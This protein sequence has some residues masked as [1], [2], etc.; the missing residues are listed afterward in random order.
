M[1]YKDYKAG[2]SEDSFWYRARRKLIQNLLRK[3]LSFP[4][5]KKL[6]ILS[7]GVGTGDELKILNKF[8][9]IYVLDIN[10]KAL[11]LVPNEFCYKKK[12]GDACE[13]PFKKDFFDV[14]VAFDVL[15]H[16]S[17]HKSAIKE[18]YRVLKKNGFFVFSVPAFQFLFSSHDKALDH[19]R[20]YS[21]KRL[22]LLL[23]SFKERRLFYWNFFMFPYSMLRLLKKNSK[24]KVESD[25]VP[26]IIDK[27]CFNLLNLENFLIKKGIKFPFGVSIFGIF[28]KR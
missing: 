4:K 5:R 16:I 2:K 3:T 14:V 17:N 11:D 18:I 26:L 10:K 23:N 6:K 12:L 1:D 25:K 8:G 13:L 15:E 19:K 27:F 21:E 7:I 20:R 28:K 22:R 9:N 24:P